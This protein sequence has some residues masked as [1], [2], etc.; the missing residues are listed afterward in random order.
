MYI[1]NHHY[2]TIITTHNLIFRE[3]IMYQFPYNSRVRYYK[4]PIQS[5]IKSEELVRWRIEL[6]S[7]DFEII[8]R[9]GMDNIKVD[10]ISRL[11]G[12][13]YNPNTLFEVHEAL[14]HAGATLGEIEK[15]T[16]I[17]RGCEEI[18][19]QCAIFS[20]LLSS[21]VLFMYLILLYNSFL[22]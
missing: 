11:C 12:A 15:L 18:I 21:Q 8:Y 22:F 16:V 5:N 20:E 19:F 10:M 2:V 13:T 1:L 7:Y 9:P 17:S 3:H 4:A 14:C 6:P